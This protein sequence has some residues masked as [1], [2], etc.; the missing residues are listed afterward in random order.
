MGLLSERVQVL[1]SAEQLARIRALAR[2]EG[3][4]VGSLIREAVEV[5]YLA[6]DQAR[7]LDAVRRL[8]AMRLPVDDWETMER[9]SIRWTSD[10]DADPVR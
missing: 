9:E 1:F 5:Q 4:S 2:R 6:D 10:D 3:R 8:A 7:R